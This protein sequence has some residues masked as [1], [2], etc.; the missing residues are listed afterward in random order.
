MRTVIIPKYLENVNKN[1]LPHPELGDIYLPFFVPIFVTA[2][3]D[4][5]RLSRR[6]EKTRYCFKRTAWGKSLFLFFLLLFLPLY[7]KISLYIFS[8][9]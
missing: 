2:F 3:F 1:Y 7:D 8:L 4:I 9:L 6:K 5:F